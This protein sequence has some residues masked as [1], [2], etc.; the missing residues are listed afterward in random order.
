MPENSPLILALETS[1]SF[2]GAALLRGEEI[3]E[4]INL[5]EGLRHGTEL[6]P[7]AE[8]CLKNRG[9]SARELDAVAVDVGPGSYTGVRIGVIAAKALA[10]GAEIKL[11]GVSG[12]AA[13]AE[14]ARALADMIVAVQ[15]ARRDEI[16]A[17][18]F[19]FAEIPVAEGGEKALTPEE[20]AALA[21]GAGWAVAGQSVATYETVFRAGAKDGTVLS[22][23][24]ASPAART[25]G[26]LARYKYLAGDF[27]DPLTLQPVYLKRENA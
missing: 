17:C 25:V 5:S 24:P 11:I 16:Y 14:E 27:S 26:L 10:F 18:I 4:E 22:A 7:A 20:A 3:L 15:D 12:L 8:Q 1:S 6:L 21:G 2:G 9:L 13:L 23:L 19:S